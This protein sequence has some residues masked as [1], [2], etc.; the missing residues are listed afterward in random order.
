MTMKK[1]IKEVALQVGGSHYPTVGGV[2]LEK[3]AEVI[4]RRCAE[5]A[6]RYD[7]SNLIRSAILREFGYSDE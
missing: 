2:L 1:E 3:F 6:H 5:V 7:D 4:V